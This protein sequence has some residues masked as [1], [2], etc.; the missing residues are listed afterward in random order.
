ME[1]AGG[2]PAV[3]S[4]EITVQKG[5]RPA[6]ASVTLAPQESAAETLLSKAIDK[7][8]SV[9]TITQL[10]ALARQMKAD[11]AKE[12]FD[13]AMSKFQMDCP[14]VKKTK[15]VYEKGQENLPAEQR[16]VRYKFAPLDSIVDQV[17]KP[18]GDNGLAYTFDE[19][20]DEKYTT[21]I[22]I[23]THFLGHS[24]KTRFKLPIG[25]EQFM[26]DVQKYGARMTF[27]KRYAF[28]NAFGIMT[29]DE[30]TDA[31]DDDISQPAPAHNNQQQTTVAATGGI[32]SGQL[33]TIQMLAGKLGTTME[34]LEGWVLK[35]RKHSIGEMTLEQG[36]KF[37][38]TLNKK[39]KLNETEAAAKPAEDQSDALLDEFEK[40]ENARI[41]A[42]QAN[43]APG[44]SSPAP[45][46]S[47]PPPQGGT[48]S[49]ATY[50]AKPGETIH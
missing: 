11:R 9:E 1:K 37:I 41:A 18:M 40:A 10:V 36:K 33:Y 2:E 50:P 32:N 16:K 45:Q 31:N 30:D 47:N 27:G 42:E 21:I 28:C 38:E 35:V 49:E 15:T 4:G 6:T 29:G 7:G 5:S 26:S 17:K 44:A 34:A 8:L 46:T 23:V 25:T 3:V 12:A 20:K 22:C 43:N 13:A 24:Q 48:A 19:E 39:L 14:T